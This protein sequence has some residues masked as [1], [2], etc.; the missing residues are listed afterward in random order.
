M[1]TIL[2]LALLLISSS[3]HCQTSV[4]A[5]KSH[6]GNLKNLHSEPDNFGWIEPSPVIDSVISSGNRCV[7][8]VGERWGNNRFKD[9]ICG[10]DNYY[11]NRGGY[12]LRACKGQYGND[13]KYIGFKNKDNDDDDNDNDGS[14]NFWFNGSPH[15][16]GVTGLF[17]LILLSFLAYLITPIF[18][19]K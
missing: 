1:R 5:L 18:N 10:Q 6:S 2:I 8:V 16:N 9:T 14:E 12:S 13:A 3:S 11:L 19:K 17:G 4:I 15:Q 7:I